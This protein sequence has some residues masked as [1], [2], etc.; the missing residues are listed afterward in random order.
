MS[1]D[2]QGLYSLMDISKKT[3]LHYNTIKKCVKEGSLKAS[4][5]ANG[6]IVTQRDFNNFKKTVRFKKIM[7]H[8]KIYKI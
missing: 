5:F 4:K 1:D 7:E 6:Y 3:G 2:L 8:K